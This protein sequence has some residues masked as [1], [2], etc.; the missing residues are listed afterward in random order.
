MRVCLT[1][2]GIGLGRGVVR[3]EGVA[4][5]GSFPPPI[6]NK[7]PQLDE[8]AVCM[9]GGCV[10]G[11]DAWFELLGLGLFPSRST[12]TNSSSNSPMPMPIFIPPPSLAR[13]SLLCAAAGAD[14]GN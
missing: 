2:W 7:L 5:G 6:P 12:F 9:L 11:W 14:W 3:V 4:A 8:R 10:D 13:S 1:T